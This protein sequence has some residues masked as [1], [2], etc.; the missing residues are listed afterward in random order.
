[1]DKRNAIIEDAVRIFDT[2][3]FRAVGID[4]LLGPSGVSTRTF[5]KYF[6]SRDGLVIAVLEARHRGFMAQLEA[7]ALDVDSVGVLFDT[8]RLWMEERGARGCMLLRARSEY[9]EANEEIV[10]LVHRQKCEFRDEVAR[11]V[12]NDLGCDDTQLCAQLWLLFEGA[13]AAAGVVGVSVV[14]GAK[15]AA[16]VLIAAARAR[17]L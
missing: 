8:L 3:G 17:N 12:L 2:E 15:E 11:R 1:M 13:T 7:N 16:L 14:E 10:A 6:G 5:Y 4:R 9:A